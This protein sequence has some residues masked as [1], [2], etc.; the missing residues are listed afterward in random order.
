MT[1]KSNVERPRWPHQ[2]YA[3]KEV[4]AAVA[5]GKNWIVV[6]SPTGG[7]KTQ[8][9]GDLLA[10]YARAQ[11]PAVVYTNK[12]LLTSQNAKA[13]EDM[14]LDFGMRA[15]G[16]GVQFESFIQ[17]ASM[18]TEHSRVSTRNERELHKAEIVI[19][20]EAHVQMGKTAKAILKKH[21]EEG[22]TVVGITA[23]PLDMGEMYEHLIVAGTNS[24][25]RACGALVLANHFGP[26]EP[27][28]KAFKLKQESDGDNLSESQIRKAI[29]TPTIFGRVWDWYEKL[30]PDRV[31]AVLF[32]PGVA[33][34]LW[35]A[36]KFHQKGIGA[37]HIDGN[38]IWING[39]WHKSTPDVRAQ[40]EEGSREGSIKVVCNRYVLRE[41]VNWPWIQHLILAYV[42]G[43]LQ[44]YLQ[45]GGRGLRAWP[46][47]ESLTVQDHGGAWW[48]HGS[49]NEDRHWSLEYTNGTIAGMRMERMRKNPNE[50]PWRCPQCAKI[51]KGAVCKCGFV[52]PPKR[53]R[54]VVS[55]DGSLRQMTGDIVKPR[56]ICKQKSME[57]VWEEMYW[58]SKNWKKG[59]T[60]RAAMALFAHENNYV[61]PDPDWKFMPIEEMDWFRF[62]K[63]VPRERLK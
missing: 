45:I 9:V 27:D 12:K 16:H 6:T 8:I 62:V 5:S 35:F 18:Q 20:D 38:D 7:G 28:L 48:R 58:R 39:E 56:R 32:G 21:V 33:E 26:D 47:K 22:A 42:V 57:K 40:L 46:G 1:R 11:R 52:C 34:A 19:V 31:P 37:A 15:A 3:V 53:S 30:N 29:M 17:V 61:Y 51:M 23:T 43:S 13:F 2:L 25:L 4:H 49:L 50:D 63:D 44:T 54:P 55:T 60:F 14:G 24:E 36:E 41:G 10:D 59:R